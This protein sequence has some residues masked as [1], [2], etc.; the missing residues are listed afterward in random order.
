MFESKLVKDFIQNHKDAP[1]MWKYDPNRSTF[2]NKEHNLHIEFHSADISN[3][4][5]FAVADTE[6]QEMLT[7]FDKHALR[8]YFHKFAAN[9]KNAAQ[10]AKRNNIPHIPTKKHHPEDFI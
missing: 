4:Y 9:E 1:G 5:R 7:V 10:K 2:R 8:K 6:L 3:L